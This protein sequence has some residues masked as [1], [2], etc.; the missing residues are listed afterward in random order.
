MRPPFGTRPLSYTPE[1]QIHV[2]QKRTH[3]QGCFYPAPFYKKGAG[4]K[5]I[6][7]FAAYL[8]VPVIAPLEPGSRSLRYNDQHLDL[9]N[10][11]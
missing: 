7:S 4:S 6:Y 5:S 1:I 8:E 3:I 9:E 10:R 11:K 2:K